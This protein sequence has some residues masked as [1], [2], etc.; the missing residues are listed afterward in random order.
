MKIEIEQKIEEEKKQVLRK[1]Q[2][3]IDN[4]NVQHAKKIINDEKIK[5]LGD[6]KQ[7][8]NIE[9]VNI[10]IWRVFA[11][12]I[13]YSFLGFVIETLFALVNYG[14]FESR[15]S[16]LYGPFCCIYGVGAVIIILVL[17]YKFFKNNHTLFIGGFVVGSIVEYV[18]SFLGE[19]ILN[20]KWWDYSDRFLNI[21]GRICFLY[22]VFWGLLGVYLLRVINPKIDKFIDWIKGKINVIFLRTLS[23][24]VVIFL[25]IDCLLSAYSINVFLI[26]VAVE[27][28]LPIENKVR[29]EEI[30]HNIYDNQDKSEFIYKYFNND[31]M[32][33]TY[34]NLTITLEDGTLKRV[35]DYYPE[36]K[37]Y[38]YKFDAKPIV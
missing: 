28:D 6:E 8:E 5:I 17:K 32:L 19:L 21:N 2:K 23:T 38:Y 34:P 18:V 36:I 22:S 15:K 31:K 37:I 24:G 9:K 4:E 29:V 35:S 3:I 13:I 33:L 26:R 16:F 30:Y 12:F 20:V 11:Y 10:S 27:K 1:A 14:V 25:F 7:N